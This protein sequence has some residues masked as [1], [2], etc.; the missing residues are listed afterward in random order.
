VPRDP[1]LHA[2]Y[3]VQL[4]KDFGFAD[5]AA[6]VDYLADL[7]IS[8]LYLSPILQA[9][10]GSTHGYDVVDFGRVNR[11]L[12]GLDGHAA[13]TAALAARGLGQ[14]VDIVPNHMAVSTRENAW[15]WD[16]L[17]NGP[18]SRYAAYFDIDWDPPE[19]KLRHIV[20]LP[21]LG[22][23]Y[24]RVLEA[25]QLTLGREGGSFVVRYYEHV[26]PISPRTIDDLLAAAGE[27]SRSDELASLA[28]A[29]GRLPPA[30]AT[31][32]A[33]VVERHRDK[34]VLR[35]RLAR[36]CDEQPELAAAIDAAVAH[37]NA[38]VDA[39]DGLLERQNYRL[40]F[41]RT[42]GRELD[43]RRFFDIST[44]V[45]LRSEDAQVFEDTHA[46]IAR[47]V[48]DGRIQGLRVD[49]PDGLRDPEGYLGRLRDLVGSVY[50]AVEKILE[51]DE[52]LPASWPVA[53]T[54][55]YDFLNRAGGLFVDPAA[56]EPLT[57]LYADFTGA[58]ADWAEVAYHAKQ[59]VMRDILGADVERL[60]A[61]FVAVCER[62]R[63]Y[64]D[65][66][67][68]DLRDALR[69]V[70]AALGVYRTYVRAE[71]NQVTPADR[72][73]VEAAIAAARAR[74][75]DVD[76]DLLRFLQ[77]VLLLAPGG[78]AE[79][80]LAM[81]FQQVSASV[82]AKGVEDTGFYRFTRLAALNE[83]GGDPGRFGTSVE[84]FHRLNAAAQHR[85]PRAMLTTTTHDTKRSEDTRLRIALLSEL[86]DQWGAAV[87]RW[88]Y[89][90]EQHHRDG[91]P[92]RHAEYLLYQTLVGAFPLT[93]ER[94]VAYME[95]A[96]KEA[97]LHTAWIAP[98]APYDAA[99]RGFVE[100]LL[101]DEAF[102]ADLAAFVGPILE[103][104]YVVS[105]AQMLLKLT[106]PG[107]PDV[108][109]GTELWDTSLV[110]PDNRRAVDYALRRRLLAETRDLDAAAVWERRADGAPK[111]W[112][113]QRTLA[114][115]R[116]RAAAFGSAGEYVPLAAA[117]ERDAHVVAYTRGGEVA[118]VVPRL[119][120][121]LGG[122]WRDTTVALP[123]G[124][125]RDA[126]TGTTVD[127][128]PVRVAD[129]LAGFPVAL[130]GAE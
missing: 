37:T 120:M 3:R 129:V 1:E 51:P 121:R 34:E 24:G 56:E 73:A 109:Q 11:E 63:R 124:R 21:I 30:Y 102:T 126:F 64:R 12:G 95:K 55:G 38:D 82:M 65:Y 115:R 71:A 48:A 53:G 97:K 58:P 66:T 46:C 16:V 33:S 93:A 20:L 92:D 80:E 77:G 35:E 70:I 2:T 130:L 40:A 81:R 94:A 104:A 22:D 62:H 112:L 8:H 91:L 39:L 54:T 108:Y 100:R 110:D 43:Y 105:L 116:A 61:L 7:G 101:G 96:S 67:R 23:H 128:G 27:A 31:D 87:W 29:F 19:T 10:A 60:V 119:V 17:E 5:A 88:S 44:L 117:G 113:L 69:E 89:M 18:A 26:V 36:L 4:N 85:W 15:W 47:L 14:I 32:R 111:L 74:R 49:H 6:L 127:G 106:A 103:G 75:P 50:V 78:P 59:L 107:V 125:W 118:V 79:S 25:G 41:W 68:V 122:D 52:E 84:E 114:L 90:N 123:P 76:D 28:V 72:R 13:L 99:L 45:A 42:A 86:P 83:V 98:A 57:R 9:T